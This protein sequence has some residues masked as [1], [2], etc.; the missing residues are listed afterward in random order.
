M[1]L[2]HRGS[3]QNLT[4]NRRYLDPNRITYEVRK[5]FWCQRRFLNLSLGASITPIAVVRRS[6][7]SWAE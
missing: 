7:R 3:T 4:I 6:T 1:D 2:D 5:Y